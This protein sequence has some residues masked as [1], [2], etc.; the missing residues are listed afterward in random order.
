MRNKIFHRYSKKIRYSIRGDAELISV[1]PTSQNKTK[2]TFQ[3]PLIIKVI[4]LL[5]KIEQK[6]SFLLNKPN[7]LFDGR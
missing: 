3:H 2:L 1:H 7:E 4:K 6:F 5:S